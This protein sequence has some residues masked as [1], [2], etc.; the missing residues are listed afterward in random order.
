MSLIFHVA[1]EKMLLLIEEF[2]QR[3]IAKMVKS[4]NIKRQ[5]N[6]YRDTSLTEAIIGHDSRI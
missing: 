5:I 4:M 6:I 2:E 1:G 3:I